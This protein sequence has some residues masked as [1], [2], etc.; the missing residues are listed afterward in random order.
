MWRQEPHAAQRV[1]NSGDRPGYYR[2]R[3]R[4]HG[5]FGQYSVT[6]TLSDGTTG[7]VRPAWTSSNAEVASV[8]SGGRVEGRGHG[9][10]NLTASYQG[11]SVSKTVQ[12]V[13]DYGGTWE[14]SYVIRACTDTGDLTDHDGGWCLSGA[15]RVGRV[16][17]I[18]MTLVQ[19]GNNLNEI[20]RSFVGSPDTITGV[21]S[22]DG[23]L[24]FAART[25]TVTD[26]YYHDVILEIVQASPWDL[27][28]DGAG[29][30]TGRW[31][32]DL[33]SFVAVRARHIPNTSSSR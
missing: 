1:W 29:G 12:V 16:Q 13:N 30:M 9:S 6:A 28:L 21:V 15:G 31:S 24:N 22:A 18:T 3:R 32:E 11:R 33:T 4:S 5:F 8:D 25:W 2:A 26:F 7:T 20:T 19:S 14:G 27:N 17:S 23:R 10:T